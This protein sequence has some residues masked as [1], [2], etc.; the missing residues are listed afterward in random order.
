M[1]EK[2]SEKPQETRRKILAWM[3]VMYKVAVGEISKDA[4]LRDVDVSHGNNKYERYPLRALFHGS[5]TP[6]DTDTIHQL[7]T[8]NTFYHSTKHD[9][10]A[11]GVMLHTIQ[12]SYTRGHCHRRQVAS[13]SPKK[14]CEILN[15]H[16]YKGQD[17]HKREKYD[18]P[19]NMVESIDCSNL[20]NFKDMDGCTDAIKHCTRLINGWLYREPWKDVRIWL[21]T[22]VFKI[23]DDATPSNIE[24]N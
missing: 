15:F 20:E 10:R 2:A 1:A 9:R 13:G 18:F 16:C 12:D 11:L 3:E 19:K 23:A 17:H 21:E 22:E 7:L 5:T 14:Y 8:T 4:R 24:V 6:K